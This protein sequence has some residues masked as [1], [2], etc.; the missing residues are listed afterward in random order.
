MEQYLF[1]GLSTIAVFAA[2]MMVVSKKP[3]HSLLYLLLCFFTLAGH[4]V[5]LNAQFLA[6]VHIIVYAGAI[7]VL[8]LFTVMLLNL[9]IRGEL[10]K[11]L[12]ARIG[13]VVAGG[14]LLVAL[15]GVLKGLDNDPALMHANNQVGVLKNISNVLF[16]EYVLPFEVA[17][18]LFLT[19]MVG[20]V[21]LGKDETKVANK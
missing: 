7:M 17:S 11:P 2:I 10:Y 4:Y 21:M 16:N 8:F 5:L 3:I 20:A 6:I 9:N 14:L 15:V 1:Y 18:I 19:A 13:A 12:L